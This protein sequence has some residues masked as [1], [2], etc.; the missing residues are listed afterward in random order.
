MAHADGRAGM[1]EEET[2]QALED[3]RMHGVIIASKNPDG[4]V[5]TA[6]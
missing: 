2:G 3:E 5:I 1:T 6:R 4:L